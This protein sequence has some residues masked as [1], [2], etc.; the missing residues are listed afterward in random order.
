MVANKVKTKMFEQNK[1][2][3]WISGIKK[4]EYKGKY[5]RYLVHLP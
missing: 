3:I 5:R 4:S 1:V 2:M